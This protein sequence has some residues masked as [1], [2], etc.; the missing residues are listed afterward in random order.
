MDSEQAGVTASRDGT[1]RRGLAA[2]HPIVVFRGARAAVEPLTFEERIRAYGAVMRPGEFFSHATAAHL[3]GLPGP[4]PGVTTPLHVSVAP[5]Q[6]A[7]RRIGVRSHH[8]WDPAV[9]VIDAGYP[10]A[11]PASTFCHLSDSLSL[12][13]L[14]VLG[15]AVVGHDEEGERCGWRIDPEAL[16]SRAVS[17]RGRGGR[18]AREAV[19]WVRAGAESPMETRLRLLLLRAGLPEPELNVE[20]YDDEGRFVARVDLV[21]RD[22]RVVV[23]Y[24]SD[25]HRTDRDQYERDIRRIEAIEAL[26]YRVVRVRSSGVL[27]DPEE[28][29]VRVRRALL[30]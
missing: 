14:V 1:T 10:V 29:V 20:L 26:G 15:D 12:E 18:R 28:T 25:Q 24:D 8:L 23:E 6:R 11:D 17:F 2:E 13:D 9:T 30:G 3:L 21:Y 19:P 7:A 4:R 5:P 27:L 22:R 16:T